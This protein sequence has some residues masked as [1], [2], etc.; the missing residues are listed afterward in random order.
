MNHQWIIIV[1]LLICLFY[2]N[3]IVTGARCVYTCTPHSHVH[4]LLMF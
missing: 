2:V 4:V 3:S 1:I